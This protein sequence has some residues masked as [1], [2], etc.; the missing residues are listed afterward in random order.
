MSVSVPILSDS[1]RGFRPLPLISR[2]PRREPQVPV[3]GRA[4]RVHLWHIGCQMNDADREELAAQIA[5]I[6]CIPETA[7]DDSDIAVLITCTVRANAEQKVFGKFRELIPWKRA[8]PGRAIALTGCMAVEHGE[9]LL[10][11]L[12]ELDYVFD[13]REPDGFLAKLQALHA[14]NLEGPVIVPASDRLSAYVAVMGGCNEMCTYCIVPFVR[15]R[16]LSR[17]L[18]EVVNHVERLVAQGVREVTLLGQNVNSYHDQVNHARLPGAAR[19]RR[20]RPR[21]VAAAVPDQPSAQRAAR[22][23]RRDARPSDGLRATP[24]SGAGR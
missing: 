12:P 24:P 2:A 15:G 6:G 20:R 21:P 17:P 18:P 4:P 14:P 3:L 8:R 10:D 13:V 16:E 9:A 11:R 5:D 19:R 7:L 1:A 22:A 23:V